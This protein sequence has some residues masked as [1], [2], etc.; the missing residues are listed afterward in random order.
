M[1]I[2]IAA[3][4]LYLANLLIL[5]GIAFVMLC[6][7][8]WKHHAHT[9]EMH[10]LEKIDARRQQVMVSH[11]DSAF[12]GSILAGTLIVIVSSIMVAWGDLSNPYF[13]V[14][15]VLYFTVVH[16]SLVLTGIVGLSRALAH[17]PFRFPLIGG[18]TYA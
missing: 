14:T 8:W 2:A 18:R 3:E 7:L 1:R 4:S 10:S 15:L 9:S 13:W 12:R 11:L 5:P 16:T 6:I 17:K